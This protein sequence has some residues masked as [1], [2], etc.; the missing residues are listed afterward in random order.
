MIHTLQNSNGMTV[1][2]LP[3]GGIIQGL[4][5]PDR[6]GRYE[7]V[8]LGFDDEQDYEGEH[9]YFGALI[10]RYGNRI[11]GGRFALGDSEF[12]LARNLGEDHL[13]GGV[14]GFDKVVW[15]V[16]QAGSKLQLRYTSADG[17]E[18]YPGEL[19]VMVTYTLTDDNELRIDYHATTTE[20]TV[21]NLTSHPYF[22][23]SR[24]DSVADHELQIFASRYTPVDDRLI[25][26]GQV[27]PVE[28]T[29][30]DFRHPA[31]IGERIDEDD[32]QLRY[33][34]GYD[35]NW[36]LDKSAGHLVPAARVA[37]PVSGRVME[38]VTTEPGLQFYS[39]NFLQGIRGKDGSIY[40]PRSGFCLETQ[41][42]PDSPN[43]ADFPSTEL[44][45]GDEYQSTTIY[46]FSTIAAG[47]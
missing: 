6:H 41:H 9:P 4:T 39:G 29:P 38:V 31:R 24:M 7:D 26:T 18:G 33:G 23:L 40:G 47:T 12:V 42:F 10:G 32:A 17:E 14:R 44:M 36:V 21:V 35:H 45:P 30:L 2:V 46:R 34:G 1:S 13:H 15:V 20:P 16:E 8:V 28:G 5:A 22:N 25:P 37:D 43:H 27:A 3:L 19:A 11:A